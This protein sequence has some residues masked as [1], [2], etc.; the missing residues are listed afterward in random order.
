MEIKL[1]FIKLTNCWHVREEPKNIYIL[2]DDIVAVE[3]VNRGSHVHLK[4][5]EWLGVTENS[6]TVMKKIE[7]VGPKYTVHV[8]PPASVMPGKMYA[9]VEELKADEDG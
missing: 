1:G 5:R 2:V 3:G 6:D 8:T 9:N 4:N 7:D